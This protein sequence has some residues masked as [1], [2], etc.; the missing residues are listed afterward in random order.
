MTE[1]AGHFLLLCAGGRLLPLH[2]CVIASRCAPH[3]RHRRAGACP[4]RSGH[5]NKHVQYYFHLSIP[6]HNTK[7]IPHNGASAG[8]CPRPTVTCQNR[9]NP[10]RLR[11]RHL[12]PPGGRQEKTPQPGG[13]GV[14]ILKITSWHLRS[15]QPLR[16]QSSLPSSRCLRP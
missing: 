3:H 1:K 4:R 10:H 5:E 14:D 8:A 2:F 15:E 6:T 12:P 16:Q 7:Q 13:W 11:R 9:G